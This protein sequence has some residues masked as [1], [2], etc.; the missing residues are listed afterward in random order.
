MKIKLTIFS[1][2]AIMI[3]PINAMAYLDP[4]AGSILLQGII[5]AIMAGF[6]IIRVYWGKILLLFSKNKLDVEAG[7]D[8]IGATKEE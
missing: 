4:G 5:G 6:L 1:I 3:L 8:D 2:I 7:A